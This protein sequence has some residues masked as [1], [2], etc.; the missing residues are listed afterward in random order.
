[1][2]WAA[3][4]RANWL[5]PLHFGKTMSRYYSAAELTAEIDKSYRRV[6][7]PAAEPLHRDECKSQASLAADVTDF[8]ADFD[9]W[10]AAARDLFEQQAEIALFCQTWEVVLNQFPVGGEPLELRFPPVRSIESIR[11]VDMSG[12]TQTMADGTFLK[13]LGTFPASVFPLWGYPWPIPRIQPRAVVVTF[14]T[15]YALPVLSINATGETITVDQND[16]NVG[17]VVRFGVSGGSLPAPLKTKTDY[18]VVTSSG[19]TIQVSDTDGGEPLDLGDTATG[20]IWVGD[21]PDQALQAVRMLVA[22]FWR[23]RESTTDASMASVP[24][25][26]ESL[27]AGCRWR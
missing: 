20:Q 6:R 12:A 15:G 7:S 11:Y 1:M 5:G 13:D 3:T 14:R 4:G 8:D 18:Y 2:R 26:F 19:N 23:N 16:L 27:V 10:I 9:R 24:M 17:D 21:I 25:G 22:H